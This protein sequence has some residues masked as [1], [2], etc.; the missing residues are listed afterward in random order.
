MDQIFIDL[1]SEKNHYTK[2]DIIVSIILII[3][4]GLILFLLAWC[5]KKCSQSRTNN[6]PY[7]NIN[8]VNQKNN[9]TTFLI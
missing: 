2:E 3:T 6:L 7:R 9:L 5:I 4:L 1:K 8:L